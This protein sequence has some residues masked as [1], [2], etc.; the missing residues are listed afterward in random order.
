[1][2]MNHGQLMVFLFLGLLISAPLS[3]SPQD[4]PSA[5][6]KSQQAEQILTRFLDAVGG[7][8]AYDAIRTSVSKGTAVDWDGNRFPIE[9]Y[10]KFP[11]KVLRVERRQKS[12]IRRGYTGSVW[13]IREGHGKPRRLKSSYDDE[14][15]TAFGDIMDWR[16][17]M[18]KVD[19]AGEAD[20]L[21]RKVYVLQVVA[22]RPATLYFDKQTGLLFRRDSR[23]EQNVVETYYTNYV[24]SAGVKLP[25]EVGVVYGQTG[26]K[27]VTD[28]SEVQV[29]V[30]LDDAMFEIPVP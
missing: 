13:W 30:P 24:A 21:D 7:I 29:N 16:A 20:V 6:T 3:V 25:R 15:E 2:Q 28:V 1:M 23:R 9:Q 11:N 10:W 14:N 18:K 22:A 19:F 12:E 17:K 27:Y 8:A 4:R 5:G 26:K